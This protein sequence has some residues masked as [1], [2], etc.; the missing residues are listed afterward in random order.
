MDTI[1]QLF[2]DNFVFIL[3]ILGAL[4]LIRFIAKKLLPIIGLL[5]VAG[6]LI[7]G[8]TGDDTFLNKTIDSSTQAVD[9]IKSEVGT[10]KFKRTSDTT[11]EV[12][13][14]SWSVKGDETTKLA[15]MTMGEKIV[16]I[17]LSS[18]HKLLPE[19]VQK[20]INM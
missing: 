15:T 17:P 6:L 11:F 14:G 8:F 18:L 16:E 20:Q 1:I 13:T 9:T 7:Y 5:F 12:S 4:I 19:D 3:L 10:A 2:S